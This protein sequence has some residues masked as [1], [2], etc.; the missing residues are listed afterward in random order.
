MNCYY[1]KVHHDM[2]TNIQTAK[3]RN[4][5]WIMI[6]HRLVTGEKQKIQ[7]FKE[8]LSVIICQQ[9][10]MHQKRQPLTYKKLR[11]YR[12]YSIYIMYMFINRPKIP[13]YNIHYIIFIHYNIFRV[14]IYLSFWF[15]SD[16]MHHKVSP[17]EAIDVQRK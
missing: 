16:L 14:I 15:F 4:N 6:S 11:W 9:Q 17:F 5:T 13:T 12:I 10:E 8:K 3:F 1:A 2:W 7:H